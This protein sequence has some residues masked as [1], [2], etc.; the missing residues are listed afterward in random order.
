M[1]FVCEKHFFYYT[2]ISHLNRS[3]YFASCPFDGYLAQRISCCRSQR[4]NVAQHGRRLLA[5]AAMSKPTSLQRSYSWLPRYT[6][7]REDG[8]THIHADLQTLF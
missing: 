7:S 2:C 3:R 1:R 6:Y 4:N 8:S 5:R